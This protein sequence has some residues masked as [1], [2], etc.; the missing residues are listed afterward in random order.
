MKI[1]I[2]FIFL[3]FSVRLNAAIVDTVSIYSAAMKKEHKAVVIIPDSYK[4]SK[5]EYPVV[6]L[7]HGY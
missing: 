5:K 7:L 1:W 6:Y 2:A 3:L 4:N